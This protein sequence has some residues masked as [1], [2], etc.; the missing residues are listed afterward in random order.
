MLDTIGLP[1][2]EPLLA[3]IPADLRLTRPLELPPALTELE[4]E[5]LL[6]ARAAGTVGAGARVSFQG[7]GVY[8]HF[9]PAVVDEV[10]GRGEFY[11]AY[12]PYQAEASQGTLQAFFEFQSLLCTLTGMEVANASLYDGAS[13]VAEGVL[14]AQRVT[15]RPRKIVI[16]GAV[17]PESVATVETYLQRLGTTIVHVPAREGVVDPAELDAVLDDQT[18]C[19]VVQSP[20][21][22]GHLEDVAAIAERAHHVGALCVQSYHPLS[23]GLLKRP[24]DLGVDIAVAE[25]QSLGIPLQYGG[26]Y[27]GLFTCRR[28]HVRKLPGRLI[29][30]TVDRLGRRCFVLNLQAREQHIRRDKATSNICTNQG[31]MALRATVYLALLGPRGLR[32]AAE[33]ACRLAHYAAD[34]FAAAGFARLASAP[35]FH[36]FAI[37]CDDVPAT[38]TRARAAGFELGPTL[39]RLGTIPGL[40]RDEHD[41][42]LLVAV[43]ESRTREEIDR[44]VAA[45]QG[46]NP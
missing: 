15:D 10:T 22:L 32:E 12:T 9:V 2:L 5:R 7:G 23:L 19:V 38:M 31:L 21:V 29:G 40:T 28:E 42:G 20:N 11:T 34:Q 27:L 39:T 41:H 30:E 43:T 46:S 33:R 8:D 35:F 3:Q 17:H 14:M 16:A 24:G 1:S 25:G 4:L 18:A 37:R 44:L 45:C 13:A 36:E 6:R 26:P